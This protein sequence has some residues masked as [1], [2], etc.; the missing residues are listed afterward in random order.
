M[1]VSGARAAAALEIDCAA[2]GV[3]CVGE[4]LSGDVAVIE[5]RDEVLFIALVDVLG[6]GA[7]AYAVAKMA[8]SFLR[9]TWSSDPAE[10]ML[11]LHEELRGTRGAVAAICALD[12]TSGDSSFAGIGDTGVV[13]MGP[14]RPSLYSKEGI[15][16]SRIRAPQEQRF[17]L[18]PGD[19]LI[20]HTDGVSSEFRTTLPPHSGSMKA[21]QLARRIVQEFRRPHDDATCIVVAAGSTE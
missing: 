13:G 6:H 10:T 12:T 8:A 20:L 17:R 1:A 14:H 7:S 9:E 18:G 2:F 5:Q 11:A 19:I 3:P 16:G 15:L 4:R 21:D